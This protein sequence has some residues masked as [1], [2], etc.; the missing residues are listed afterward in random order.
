MT[1]PNSSQ[2]P[3]R[4]ATAMSAT[5]FSSGNVAGGEHLAAPHF[6]HESQLGDKAEPHDEQ[7]GMTHIVSKRVRPWAM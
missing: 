4:M 6:G 7:Y 1:Q 2:I 3:T 5:H